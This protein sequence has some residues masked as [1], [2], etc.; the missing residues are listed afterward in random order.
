MRT[1][2]TLRTSSGHSNGALAVLVT[3]FVAGA[4]CGKPPAPSPATATTT[5]QAPTVAAPAT[6]APTA[7]PTPDVDAAIAPPDAAPPAPDGAAPQD[8]AGPAAPDVAAAP[9]F[10]AGLIPAE[11][12]ESLVVVDPPDRIAHTLAMAAGCAAAKGP[13][14]DSDAPDPCAI[15]WLLGAVAFDAEGARAA[16]LSVKDAGGCAGGGQIAAEGFFAKTRELAPEKAKR[17]PRTPDADEDDVKLRQAIW[18]WLAD[19]GKAGYAT[20]APDLI[21]A[22]AGVESGIRGATPLVRLGP[23]LGGMYLYAVSGEGGAKVQLVAADNKTTFALGTI[24]DV[25]AKCPKSARDDG[26]CA[27]GTAPSF[28]RVAL[29]PDRKTLLVTTTMGDGMHCGSDYVAHHAWAVPEA[30][31]PK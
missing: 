28:V 31:W 16:F 8:D 2:R 29:T 3:S 1:L 12:G 20:P 9:A 21:V 27:D 25:S 22:T 5:L 7:S 13:P 11:L 18:R 17:F 19:L 15:P 14:P 26:L 30:L 4:A 24:A 10:P 23:P 6:T